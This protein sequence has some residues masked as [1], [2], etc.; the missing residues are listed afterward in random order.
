MSIKYCLKCRRVVDYSVVVP[1]AA[2]PFILTP[3][4]GLLFVVEHP[5]VSISKTRFTVLGLEDL[6]TLELTS[7]ISISDPSSTKSLKKV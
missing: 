3:L 7:D 5:S 1:D 6:R 2:P 4:V